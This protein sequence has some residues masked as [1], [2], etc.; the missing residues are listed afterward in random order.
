MKLRLETMRDGRIKLK[1]VRYFRKPDGKSSCTTV[2]VLGFKD[3]LEKEVADPIAWGEGIA[4]EMTDAHKARNGHAMVDIDLSQKL[5]GIEL[6]SS[7]SWQRKNIGYAA[8]SHIYHLL[9]MDQ[10]WKDRKARRGFRFDV[11]AVFR[12]LVYNRLLIPSAKTRAWEDRGFFFEPFNFTL[13]N[14]YDSLSFFNS[15]K[16]DFVRRIDDSITRKVGR[17][18]FHFYYDVTNYYFE[19]DDNDEDMVD[20]DGNV[21]GKGLR[22]KGCSKSTM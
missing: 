17:N 9:E 14:I 20:L 15:Y 22:K 2:R 10:F 12:L 5:E 18:K 21:V 19:I 8:F 11:E 4:R 1:I 3:E 13:D 16:E 7:D 6:T